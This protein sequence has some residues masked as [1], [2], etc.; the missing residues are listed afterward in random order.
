MLKGGSSKKQ[1][2]IEDQGKK[3]LVACG[4]WLVACGGRV[5]PNTLDARG[6]GGFLSLCCGVRVDSIGE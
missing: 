3:R 6:V 5:R 1:D 2:R 4:M